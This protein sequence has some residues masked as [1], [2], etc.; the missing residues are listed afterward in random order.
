MLK[1]FKLLTNL[2]AITLKRGNKTNGTKNLSALLKRGNG[3][4]ELLTL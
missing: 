3:H 2:R 1:K 4:N